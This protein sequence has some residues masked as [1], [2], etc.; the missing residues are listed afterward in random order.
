MIP[1]WWWGTRAAWSW[2]FQVLQWS[3]FVI[4]AEQKKKYYASI[5]EFSPLNIPWM[6]RVL[7]VLMSGRTILEKTSWN[8]S[9]WEYGV[10]IDIDTRYYC[11]GTRGGIDTRLSHCDILFI[12]PAESHHRL[13]AH[14][15]GSASGHA[16]ARVVHR[17]RDSRLEVE[18]F[19]RQVVLIY[20]PS[21]QWTAN[22]LR[23]GLL[24]SPAVNR[25]EEG[26]AALLAIAKHCQFC[27]LANKVETV[28]CHWTCIRRAPS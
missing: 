11:C 26:S 6:F 12:V 22:E 9:N 14:C 19:D 13:L 27:K 28:H 7:Y 2:K 24:I 21:V 5:G 8:V 25:P 15:W 3:N 16:A 17:R 20:V 4:P 18:A 10:S 23:T 1:Y